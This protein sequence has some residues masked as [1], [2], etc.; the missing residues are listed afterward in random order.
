VTGTAYLEIIRSPRSVSENV[1]QL[2]RRATLS[3]L[4]RRWQAS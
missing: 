3:A 2:G 4:D 1:C